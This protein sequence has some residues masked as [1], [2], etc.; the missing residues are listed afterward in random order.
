MHVE[1]LTTKIWY[2]SILES[3]SMK[4]NDL[5]LSQ[6]LQSSICQLS[7][8]FIF[9]QESSSTPTYYFSDVNISQGSVP[10]IDMLQVWQGL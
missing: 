5:F 8:K 1:N 6:Q 9:Q 4:S 10:T 3:K 7:H 2:S